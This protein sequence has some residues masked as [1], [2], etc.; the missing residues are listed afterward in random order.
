MEMRTIESYTKRY[1][2]FELSALLRV[3]RFRSRL[4]VFVGD[5][6]DRL[7]RGLAANLQGLRG[8]RFTAL[9]NGQRYVWAAFQCPDLR[10]G[11][12]RADN[13]ALA[14]PVEPDRDDPW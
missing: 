10:R 8:S 11:R 3:Q 14:V 4:D 13:D 2:L 9:V 6:V 12:R 1:L 7:Q 5:A